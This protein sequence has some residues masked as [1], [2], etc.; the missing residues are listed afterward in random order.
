MFDPLFLNGCNIYIDSQRNITKRRFGNTEKAV[1]VD[2][3]TSTAMQ[4]KF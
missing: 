2:L 1:D 4:N 3:T